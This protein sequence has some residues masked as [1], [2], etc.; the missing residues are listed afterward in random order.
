[1]RTL[2]GI[3][4]S[5]RMTLGNILGALIPTIEISKENDTFLFIADL[6]SLTTVKNATDFKNNTYA[7]AAAC[8]AFGFDFEKNTFYR[9]SDISEISELAFI[10]NCSTPYM[11]LAHNHSFKDKSEN[12]KDINTGLF[13]YPVLMASDILLF[14]TDVVPVGKDQKQHLEI[15]RDIVSIFNRTYG[16]TFKLPEARITN[17]ELVIGTDGRKMSKSYNNY[18]DIF[19]DEKDLRKSIMKI[20]TD[21]TP[22]EEPKNPEACNLFKIYSYLLNDEDKSDLEKRYLAGGIGYGTIKNEFY[23]FIIYKYKEEREKFSHYLRHQD[24]IEKIFSIGATKAKA[25]A[26][27]VMNRVRKNIGLKEK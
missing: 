11:M 2:T 16:E 25:V 21:S 8:L 27:E 12:L 3:Q 14:D 26:S 6:H 7:I 23:E 17:S 1:M 15:T 18:I 5:G 4:S 20:Q 9:Q 13:T 19:L 24:E 22:L 10:L